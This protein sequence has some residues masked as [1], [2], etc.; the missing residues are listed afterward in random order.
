M[1]LL[2]EDINSKVEPLTETVNGKKEL[3]IEGIFAQADVVNGNNRVYPSDV[4]FPEVERYIDKYVKPGR[5][6]GELEHPDYPAANLNFASHLITDLRIEGTNVIG[7]AKILNTEK[8]QQARHLL[9]GGVKLGVST[10]GLAS[11]NEGENG[12]SE[13][14][15]DFTLFAVDIVGNP[16]APDAFVNGVME[17][18]NWL[19]KNGVLRRKEVNNMKTLSESE[20]VKLVR[21]I[22]KT[23]SR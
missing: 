16:S 12:V 19:Y 5:A 4:L 9:E 10:R 22:L 6:V 3:F 20:K 13:V 23:L 17:S 1:K 14:A 8:G 21:D 7:K 15:D 11:L 18:V 2:A